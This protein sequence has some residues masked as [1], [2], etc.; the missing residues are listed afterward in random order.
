MQALILV[1]APKEMLGMTSPWILAD[2]QEALPILPIRSQI[3]ACWRGGP[4]C[5]G[6][7]S[8]HRY[9]NLFAA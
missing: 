3:L 6:L 8:L 2:N 4:N 1:L 9:R 7:G 5:G